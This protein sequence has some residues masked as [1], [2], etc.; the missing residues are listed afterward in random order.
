MVISGAI[1]KEAVEKFI[2]AHLREIDKCYSDN[3]NTPVKG[4]FSLKI[5]VDA[6]GKVIKAEIGIDEL[7]VLKSC[8]IKLAES[9]TLPAP[10]DG[11]T[12]SA[13]CFFEF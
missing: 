3:I 12:A 6:S 4:R 11:K 2:A 7:K 9:W 13:E 1:S 5:D 8:I 10:S